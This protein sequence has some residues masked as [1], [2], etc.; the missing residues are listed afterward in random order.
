MTIE[1]RMRRRVLVGALASALVSG[2]CGRAKDPPPQP[3]AP[4]VAWR[5]LG[6]WS[7]RGSL[8]TE[9]FTSDT[10]TL[11]VRWEATSADEPPLTDA[12]RRLFRLDAHSAISGRLLQQVVNHAGAGQGVDYVQQDPHVFYIVVESSQ[13]NWRFTV[14]EAIGYP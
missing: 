7:G 6:S 1:G 3:P 12:T 14:D 5:Q 4:G 8:Q 2:A 13:L 9:S 11:R 10:G